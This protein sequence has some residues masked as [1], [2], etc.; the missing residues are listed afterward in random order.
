VAWGLFTQ[1]DRCWEVVRHTNTQ[2]WDWFYFFRATSRAARHESATYLSDC[3]NRPLAYPIV[4]FS[5]KRSLDSIS[6]HI[7]NLFFDIANHEAF[8][9]TLLFADVEEPRWGP[10]EG[11]DRPQ[12]ET[13]FLSRFLN[14]RAYTWRFDRLHCSMR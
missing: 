3:V 4:L 7:K 1:S 5:A 11:T 9:R 2:K 10:D 14:L 8:V 12:P 13:I 6:Y